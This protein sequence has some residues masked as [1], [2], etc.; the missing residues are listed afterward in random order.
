M[1]AE[2]AAIRRVVFARSISQAA[3]FCAASVF[4]SPV[5]PGM[6][7]VSSGGA[8]VGCGRALIAAP[9]LG[10]EGAAYQRQ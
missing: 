5:P 6:M 1:P 3:I 7:I 4:C 2:I 9:A 10:D 8:I